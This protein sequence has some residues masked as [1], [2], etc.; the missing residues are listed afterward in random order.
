MVEIRGAGLMG[1]GIFAKIDIEQDTLLGEYLGE[2]LPLNAPQDNMDAYQF[3]LDNICIITARDYGNWT[4][5]INHSCTPNVRGD[6]GM[7][8]NRRAITFHALRD[9]SADEQLT[10]DYGDAYFG[11]M[12]INCQCDAFP[13]PHLRGGAPVPPAP[14]AQAAAGTSQTAT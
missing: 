5:Y 4:R 12:G 14:A 6:D 10:F 8:G 13:G 3:T 1:K 2:L 7:Y 9:I 11:N